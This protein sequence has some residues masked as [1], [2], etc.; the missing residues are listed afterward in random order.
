MVALRLQHQEV[1]VVDVLG[2]EAADFAHVSGGAGA[3]VGDLAESQ[4]GEEKGLAQERWEEWTGGRK[5]G[6]REQNSLN[7]VCER[8]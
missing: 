4:W 8:H 1:P 5:R 6:A 2:A 7:E 3:G